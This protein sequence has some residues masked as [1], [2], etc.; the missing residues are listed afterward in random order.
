M[1]T[2]VIQSLMVFIETMG[3]DIGYFLL[4]IPSIKFRA[5]FP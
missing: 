4:R 5:A 3:L 1:A 2:N